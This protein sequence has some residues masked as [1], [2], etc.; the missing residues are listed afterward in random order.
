MSIFHTFGKESQGHIDVKSVLFLNDISGL[1]LFSNA[2]EGK[3]S[4]YYFNL[5]NKAQTLF[6]LMIVLSSPEAILSIEP[7]LKQ[8]FTYD[9]REQRFNIGKLTKDGKI[10]EGAPVPVFGSI[11][12]GVRMEAIVSA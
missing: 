9:N 12:D 7:N 8:W 2:P 10:E 4:I 1:V 5:S 11:T 6:Q 3:S